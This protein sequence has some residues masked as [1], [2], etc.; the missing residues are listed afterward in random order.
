MKRKTKL[1]CARERNE[2]FRLNLDTALRD[3]HLKNELARVN[4][5]TA[6]RARQLKIQGEY[7]YM[8]W[9]VTETA[10]FVRYSNGSLIF[11]KRR[12]DDFVGEI[13]YINNLLVCLERIYDSDDIN[14]NSLHN[15]FSASIYSD[16]KRT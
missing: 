16:I 11:N 7:D 9:E 15:R 3:L 6:M 12:S 14:H 1:E 2:L 4:R 5:D 13:D 8:E 10:D